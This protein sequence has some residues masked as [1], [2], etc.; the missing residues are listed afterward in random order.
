MACNKQCGR[1]CETPE[2]E[3]SIQWTGIKKLNCNDHHYVNSII[4]DIERAKKQGDIERVI[5]YAREYERILL[6][7]GNTTDETVQRFQRALGVARDVL[8]LGNCQVIKRSLETGKPKSITT[9][10]DYEQIEITENADGTKTLS[11]PENQPKPRPQEPFEHQS[12]LLFNSRNQAR[13][14]EEKQK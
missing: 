14:T 3:R 4:K 9:V 2:I 7:C 5:M 8:D 12:A 11:F 13:I 6:L 1:L 10:I